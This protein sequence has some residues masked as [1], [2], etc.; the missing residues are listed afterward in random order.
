MISEQLWVRSRIAWPWPAVGSTSPLSR[1]SIPVRPVPWWWCPWNRT[2]GTWSARGWR[3]ARDTWRCGWPDQLPARPPAE[4]VR[5]LYDGGERDKAEPSGS[6]DMIGLIYPGISRLD[7]DIQ[8]AG[9]VFPCH[10]ESNCDPQLGQW[11]SRVMH[12]LPVAPRPA[13]Y[14]PLG[15]KNLDPVWIG[16]L[17]QTGRDCL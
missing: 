4:L 14:N 1:A 5:E 13:G 3:R 11:L 10:I 7:Y 12:L 6:Q 15:I 8:H 17:G 16:R 9:G 2:V